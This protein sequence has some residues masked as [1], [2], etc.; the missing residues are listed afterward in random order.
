MKERKDLSDLSPNRT[1]ETSRS[2]FISRAKSH[3][4]VFQ[5]QAQADRGLRP[6]VGMDSAHFVA[7]VTPFSV[8]KRLVQESRSFWRVVETVKG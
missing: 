3:S 5:K 2:C 6:V 7:T 4:S 8:L 1:L